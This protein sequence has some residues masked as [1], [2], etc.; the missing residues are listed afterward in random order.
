[1]VLIRTGLHETDRWLRENF[2]YIV[3]D[4]SHIPSAMAWAT[5]NLGETALKRH[6]LTHY[7]INP[8]STWAKFGVGFCF[9]HE[10]DA[11]AFKMVWYQAFDEEP[12]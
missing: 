12:E 1:V 4:V 8:D 6:S 11:A 5:D 10:V 9:A 3:E 7:E 2:P